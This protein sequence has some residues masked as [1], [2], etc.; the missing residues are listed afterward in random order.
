MGA[1]CLM[2]VPGHV[3]VIVV[4]WYNLKHDKG[5]DG[6]VE[7]VLMVGVSW[8]SCCSCIMSDKILCILC[9]TLLWLL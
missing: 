7:V 6:E 4:Q 1:V 2:V 9:W 8:Q 3:V 5:E